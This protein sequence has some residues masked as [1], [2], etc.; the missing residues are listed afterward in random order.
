MNIKVQAKL[1]REQLWKRASKICFCHVP[2][3]AGT[4]VSNALGVQTFKFQE[5]LLLPNFGLDLA[6]SARA[7]RVSCRSMRDLREELL[8]YA[9]SLP[10]YKFVS[11]HISCRPRLVEEFNV[12][13]NFVTVLRNPVD[14]WISEYVYN[15]YKSQSWAKNTLSLEE[16][17]D[18][19]VG[20]N[21]GMSYLHY[22]SHIP[23][24]F[25]GDLQA[26]INEAVC[27]LNCFAIVGISE[28]LNIFA[29]QYEMVFGKRLNIPRTN[30]SPNGT[31]QDEIKKN[32]FLMKKIEALCVAD[33]IIYQKVIQCQNDRMENQE[34]VRTA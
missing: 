29:K 27:N 25:E 26:Y 16:Y 6:A 18:S 28:N 33:Q 11:A 24:D 17:V 13:W 9:L 3:C 14:R 21:T 1:Y 32:K 23:N 20:K 10:K 7:A 5:R 2:K 31:K 30:M 19:E 12:T 34:I 15:T 4:S 8:G 22:F